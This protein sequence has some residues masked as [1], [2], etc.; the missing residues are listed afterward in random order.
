MVSD[1]GVLSNVKT[2]V[3]YS[4][5]TLA[6]SISLNRMI[7]SNYAHNRSITFSFCANGA[8]HALVGPDHGDTKRGGVGYYKD[9]KDLSHLKR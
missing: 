5:A 1:C 8:V 7:W 4:V 9:K 2:E 3:Y 6:V